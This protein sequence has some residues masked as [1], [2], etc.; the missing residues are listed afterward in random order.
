[1]QYPLLLS[2]FLA[3]SGSGGWGI[4]EADEKSGK[5]SRRR[6]NSNVC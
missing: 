3:G 6:G 2:Y 1:M 4:E 5:K